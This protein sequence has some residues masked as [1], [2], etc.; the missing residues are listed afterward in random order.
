VSEPVPATIS[1]S[2]DPAVVLAQLKQ[3]L[4]EKDV[5]LMRRDQALAAAEAIIRMHSG[6]SILPLAFDLC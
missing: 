5:Q 3:Q 2:I 1:S 4:E 6:N